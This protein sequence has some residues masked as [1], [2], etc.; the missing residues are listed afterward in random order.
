MRELPTKCHAGS[1]NSGIRTILATVEVILAI[2]AFPAVALSVGKDCSI[3]ELGPT[4][5]RQIA[6]ENFEC[7]NAKL[8]AALARVDA[9]EAAIAPFADAR[10]AVVAFNRD[11]QKGSICPRGWS[12]FEVA[13]GRFIVGAGEHDNNLRRYPSYV[14]NA[15]QA[16]GGEEMHL[17]TLDEMPSHD[18]ANGNYQFLMMAGQDTTGGQGLDPTPNEPNLLHVGRILAQGGGQPHNNLPPFIG[19]Y[20]CVKD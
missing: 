14:E 20:Y 3:K 1:T 19:L 12:Y 10:G 8:I 4:E 9:L 5:T 2:A 15:A 18:H 13:G 16:I 11:R 17:L 6:Q 7:V